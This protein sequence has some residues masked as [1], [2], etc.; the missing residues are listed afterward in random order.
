MFR[1]ALPSRRLFVIA[2]FAVSAA[3]VGATAQYS[4]PKPAEGAD[5]NP[6]TGHLIKTGLYMF[7]GTRNSLLRLT[8]NGLIVVDGQTAEHYDAL[9]AHIDKISDQAVR[10][11]ITTDHHPAPTANNTQFLADGTQIVA[12]ANVARHLTAAN[13]RGGA[14]ALPTKTY[15]DHISLTLGGIEVRLTH[16]GNAHTDADSVVYFTNLRVVAVGDLYAA[17][18]DPDF[19][20][21]GSLVG[22]G[23]VLGE[24]LKLEFDVVV[25]GS[26]PPVTRADLVAFK[27]KIDTLVSRAAA[28]VKKGV[29]KDQLMAQLKTDDLGWGFTF[30]GERLNRFYAE[31]SRTK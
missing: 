10:L 13:T 5:K 9:Q 4:R 8:A 19:S 3:T 27:G 26:G 29:A 30:T 21:G 24:L 12:H 31:L 28:L 23:P 7:S 22:W 17:M 2:A 25:P 20:S 16:F 18:P 15:D 11:L 14:T 1:K 6:L